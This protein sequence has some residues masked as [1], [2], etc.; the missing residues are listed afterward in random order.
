MT[1]LHF[2]IDSLKTILDQLNAPDALDAHPWTSTAFVKEAAGQNPDLQNVSPGKQLVHAL[3]SVFAGAMPGVSPRRG[4]R[5]DTNWGE[6]GLLAALYFAP[7]KF[8]TAIPNSLRDAWGR[9]DQSILLYQFGRADGLTEEQ[10][11]AYKLVGDESDVAPNST[12]SDWHR[13]GIQQLAQAIQTRENFL[14]DSSSMQKQAGDAERGGAGSSSARKNRKIVWRVVLAL[15]LLLIVW[16]GFKAWRVYSLATVVWEDANQMRGLG[17][18]EPSV[19]SIQLAGPRLATL[20]EDFHALREE[21]G[22]FLWIGSLFGWVPEYGGDLASARDLVILGD[23]MLTA[24]DTTY[25]AM[26]PLLDVI[27]ETNSQSGFDSARFTEILNDAQPQLREAQTSVEEAVQA[28]SRIDV[29]RLSPRVREA[30]TNYVDKMLPW[31]QDGIIIANEFPRMLGASDEGPKTYL[32]LAQNEDELRPTGGFITA[33]GTLLLQDGQISS[34]KFE[35]SGNLDN[36]DKAYPSAPWQLQQYMNSPVLVLRDTNWFVD[37]PTAALYAE[38]LYSYQND[39]SVDGVIAFD[40]HLLIEIL[41]ATGPVEVEGSS[42]LI[43]ANNVVEYM[44][45]QKVPPGGSSNPNSVSWDSKAFINK[46]TSSLLKRLLGGDFK[47]EQLA[48]VLVQALDEHHVLFQFDNPALTPVLVRRGWDGAVRPGTGDFLMMAEFNVG[49]NKTNAVVESQL[50]YEVNLSDVKAPSAWL[51][52][53][54]VN[55]AVTLPCLPSHYMQQTLIGENEQ[56]FESDYPIDRCYWSYIRVYTAP[57]VELLNA[58]PQTIPAESMIL[59]QAV[60]PQVDV[61]GPE[62]EIQEAQ[63]F[64]FLKLVQGGETVETNLRFG[65]PASVLKQPAGSDSWSYQLRVQKQPGTLAVPFTIRIQ[66]PEG[67]VVQ[68]MPV[69][70][71]FENGVILLE[72]TLRVDLELEIVFTLP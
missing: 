68:S 45:A 12:L 4:K 71:A 17:L 16:G 51:S 33:A 11:Q 70:A 23:S 38:Y 15:I 24:A 30:M 65:L 14:Q 66:L 59:D 20:R 29:N 36:W 47:W 60:P 61:L 35:G 13:K 40:Q 28:R 41:R 34:L 6:F 58:N 72:T 19:E 44:R 26:S 54:H 22:P 56:Y 8:G 50:A 5:L 42:E 55:H 48:L 21:T 32:L 62:D 46:L 9:I 69:G 27:T 64:G 25:Q 57:G 10:V 67:A 18:S 52:V 31:M 3:E 7:L 43:D 2:D 37:Y 53:K 1:S 39:H 49:F 63:G